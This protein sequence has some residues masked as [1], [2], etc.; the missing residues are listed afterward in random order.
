[1]PPPVARASLRTAPRR[2]HRPWR[3]WVLAGLLLS[4]LGAGT[5][6][7]RNQRQLNR[8]V[9]HTWATLTSRYLTGREKTPLLAGFSVHGI[10]VSAY[11]GHID[12]PEVARH[13]VRFAFIK[14]SEGATLR[15]P[16]FA[17]NWRE[18]RAAGILSGAYHYFQPNRD[19]QV[20]AAL[21]TSLVPLGPGDLPPVLDVEATRFHDVAE[22]RREVRQWLELVQAHYGVPP[23]L[24]S[25]YG[26]YRRYLA[27]H[28]DDFPLWLAHYEVDRPALPATRWI[29][30][31]HSDE[32]YVPGIRG[33]VDF[34][35]FQGSYAALQAM[36]L[37]PV[38][39]PARPAPAKPARPTLA[40][41]PA[42]PTKKAARPRSSHKLPGR[43]TKMA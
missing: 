33:T 19:G 34:N 39:A 16:R 42:S 10:D 38:A 18:A 32:A 15:D 12:W 23:I 28:F 2:P 3:R 9:R 36:R 21:F 7:Y 30:W 17:R 24:Y 31:Q 25:N 37:A 43:A 6:Y 8:Y 29:I 20:Q 5:I 22:L 14:A 26:F 11:Q 35:V 40:P 27:G 41:T 13:R 4:A 1:M